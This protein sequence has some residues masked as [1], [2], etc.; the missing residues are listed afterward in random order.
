[1]SRR[2]A[3][4]IGAFT[5]IELLVVIATIVILASMFLPVLNKAKARAQRT[6]CQNNLRQM[7]IGWLTYLHDNDGRLV[8][9]F[10]STNKY[11]W[12]LGTMTNASEAV[13]LDLLRQGKIF[14]YNPDIMLYRCPTD[15]GVVVNG[16]RLNSV[17]SYSMNAFMGARDP[18]VTLPGSDDYVPFFAKDSDLRRPSELWVLIDE[19]ERSIDD[20]FFVVD[21]SGKQWYDSPAN[22]MHRH[23]FSYC[24]T[25]ADGHADTWRIR[26]NTATGASL[27]GTQPSNSQDLDRLAAASTVSK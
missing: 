10:G 7:T 20:G 21:P 23:L 6:R 18:S 9:S 17:R 22:S 1:M 4:R 8:E 2:H 11:A 24:L 16:K 12:V 26:D 5:L 25:F 15:E 13:N 14:A 19:D 3:S 27:A